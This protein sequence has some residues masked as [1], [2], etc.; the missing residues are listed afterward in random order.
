M[1]DL[2]YGDGLWVAAG[3]DGAQAQIAWT[4]KLTKTWT[5]KGLWNGED[6]RITC[7]VRADGYWIVGGRHR[8]DQ[9]DYDDDG[10]RF[11]TSTTYYARIAYAADP[12]GTWTVKDLWSSDSKKSEVNA[13]AC[14]DGVWA[15]GGRYNGNTARIAYVAASG[16]VWTVKN[17]WN[18]DYSAINCMVRADGVWAVGGRYAGYARIAYAA[19]L[20][21]TWTMRDLW[22][23]TPDE[24][25]NGVKC[26]ACADG[27]WAAGGQCYDGSA[28]YAR[29]AWGDS[30]GGTWETR[31]LWGNSYRTNYRFEGAGNAVNDIIFADG[32]W[33]IAG[34][35]WI[36]SY[37]CA[38]RVGCADTIWGDW[39]WRN[40]WSAAGDI[41]DGYDFYVDASCI[42]YQDGGWSMAG[43]SGGETLT[44]RI[45][46]ADTVLPKLSEN[47]SYV[48]I[49]ALDEQKE[50][51]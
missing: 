26:I 18:G 28:T 2:A 17:L 38:A 12:A 20:S 8:V 1:F 49:K 30:P 45:G 39:T 42:C 47:M 50:A 41:N 11:I 24:Y 31:D 37:N 14:A 7:V 4:D 35:A 32:V 27:V 5:A 25:Y 33:A 3:K 15:A 46:Y 43:C 21:G 29:L 23:G 22:S 10:D 40:V 16:G 48:Y 51:E 34:K 19:D 36:S 44:A 6:D 9:Y 13:I